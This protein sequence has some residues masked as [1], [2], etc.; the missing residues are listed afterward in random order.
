MYIF[1]YGSLRY[2][3]ELH[4]IISKSRFV[5]LGYIEGYDMYDLGSYPGIIKGDGIVWGEV[6]EIND[7]LIKFLD[8]VEDYKGSPD[9]L[10]TRQRTRVYFDQK[11]RYYID[12]VFFYKYNRE[13]VDRKEIESGDYSAWTGMPI[14]VNYFAY[15]EN[16]NLNVLH[17]RGVDLILSEIPA[18]LLGY[19]MIFNIPCK[20]GY[21]AN[22]V[23][24]H[25]GK[26]CGYLQKVF[27]HTLNSLDKAEQHLIKYMRE[28]VK[29]Y[30]KEGKE[31]F[32]YAYISSH[33]GDER[34]PSNEYVEIIREGLKRG[35]GNSCIST[36]LDKYI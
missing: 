15:A 6:Y 20:Y 14:I 16:T 4:H 11:R 10:Y 5:G 24:E 22:L 8:E 3:F 17:S 12:N 28:V 32:A 29:V 13:I 36:G 34:D 21:C 19:K 23:E 35:W 9:D 33:K 7:E 18:Y 27:L 26:I 25:N 31:Y 1:V 2:G 30:D